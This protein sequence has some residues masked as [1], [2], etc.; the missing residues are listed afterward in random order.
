MSDESCVELRLTLAQMLY[1]FLAGCFKLDFAQAKVFVNLCPVDQVESNRAVHFLQRQHRKV[2]LDP[3]RRQAIARQAY[4][5]EAR[6]T[7]ESAMR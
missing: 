6:E 4:T 2:F 1:A 5:T 3:L 7:R